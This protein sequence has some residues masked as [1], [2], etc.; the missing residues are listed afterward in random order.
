M[1]KSPFKIRLMKSEDFDAVVKL[2]EKVLKASRADYYRQKF[3][4][5][6][7]SADR[8]PASLVAEREDGKVA[9]FL[10]GGIFIGEY[11]IS[12]EATLETIVVDPDNRNRGIGKRL[13]DEFVEHLRSLGAR[14]IS[15]LV[16][17]SN[18]KLMRFFT[19]N[20][21]T[22]SKTVHLERI[23]RD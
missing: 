14:K 16:N 7:Q 1:K 20:K 19:A 18:S 6:I 15:T 2:D 11:G 13:I 21:F 9:G 23:R 22:I 4:E 10:M 3:E 17:S 5:L 8:L 12:K